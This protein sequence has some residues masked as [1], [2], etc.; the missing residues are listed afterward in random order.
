MKKQEGQIGIVVPI[1]LFLFVLVIVMYLIQMYIFH[2]VGNDTEDA[3]ATSNLASAVIDI[4]EFGTTHNIIISAPDT[5]YELYKDAL[6]VNMGLDEQWNSKNKAA[7]SGR[8]EILEYT[9]YNV[10]GNDI[11]IYCFGEHPYSQTVAGGKG[12]IAAP[13]GQIIETTSVYSKITFPVSG[14]FGIFNMNVQ[15]VKDKL[16]DIPRN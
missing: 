4:Q 3:L 12:M 7:I 6:K 16:V 13:S 11:E 10:R 14:I 5:A 9:I 15:A 2:I 8:V 1:F